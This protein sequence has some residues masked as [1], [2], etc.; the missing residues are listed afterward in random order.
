MCLQLWSKFL[1]A[2][3]VQVWWTTTSIASGRPCRRCLSSVVRCSWEEG[4]PCSRIDPPATLATPTHLSFARFLLII[5]AD[6]HSFVSR[7]CG[8][9][10]TR[11][12]AAVRD[13]AE[14][15]SAPRRAGATLGLHSAEDG[16]FHVLPRGSRALGELHGTRADLA[17]AADTRHCLRSLQCLVDWSGRETSLSQPR[18]RGR[19]FTLRYLSVAL[20]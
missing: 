2:V 8:G 18:T 20:E 6:Q 12:M 16:F 15:V 13:T 4:L 1:S 19:R 5:S 14:A 3:C 17:F 11:Q 9:V 10:G 7:A